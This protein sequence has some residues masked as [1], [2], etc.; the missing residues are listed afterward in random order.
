MMATKINYLVRENADPKS[1]QVSTDRLNPHAQVI[2]TPTE[3]IRNRSKE[4][5]DRWQLKRASGVINAP[6]KMPPLRQVHK[7]QS[8][9]QL[10]I[11]KEHQKIRDFFSK[12]QEENDGQV[13]FSQLMRK[14]PEKTSNKLPLVS[15]KIQ[16]EN[17]HFHHVP[18][19][20][21]KKAMSLISR[22]YQKAD[23]FANN[24]LFS[25]HDE[26]KPFEIKTK[27]ETTKNTNK[28]VL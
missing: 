21:S 28:I 19:K 5:T 9:E 11:M 2:E 1:S 8:L 7:Q 27:A 23:S 22:H 18:N 17:N 6:Q 14:I 26:S 4:S 16:R 12:E 13:S 24:S 25:E 3:N 10:R 15:K 20:V